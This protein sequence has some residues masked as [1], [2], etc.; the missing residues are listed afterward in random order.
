MPVGHEADK[1]IHLFLLASHPLLALHKLLPHKQE[2][3]LTAVRVVSIHA[4]GVF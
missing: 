1:S 2:L 4:A 3:T